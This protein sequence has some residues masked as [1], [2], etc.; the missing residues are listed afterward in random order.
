MKFKKVQSKIFEQVT[1]QTSQSFLTS[2]S[3]YS[4][5]SCR[6]LGFTALRHFLK[7][8]SAFQP[9]LFLQLYCASDLSQYVFRR[10]VNEPYASNHNT[11]S[12]FCSQSKAADLTASLSSPQRQ[13]YQLQNTTAHVTTDSLSQ[14]QTKNVLQ[15]RLADKPLKSLK[16]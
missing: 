13:H 16:S 15:T 5:W 4:R 8:W 10:T 6:L 9:S 3:H 14:R 2:C 12:A 11:G 7:L 1:S